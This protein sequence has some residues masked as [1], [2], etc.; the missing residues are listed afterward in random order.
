MERRTNNLQSHSKRHSHL[1]TSRAD[2]NGV[3]AHI[4]CTV[5][6]YMT[7]VIIVLSNVFKARGSKTDARYLSSLRRKRIVR[8]SCNKGHENLC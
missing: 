6:R 5:I 1:R 7:C 3:C 8:Q 2:S 4:A